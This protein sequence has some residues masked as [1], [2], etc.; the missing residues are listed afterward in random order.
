[1]YVTHSDSPDTP[2]ESRIKNLLYT[3]IPSYTTSDH[4]WHHSPLL[5]DCRLTSVPQKPVV[6]LL[7]LPP[8]ATTTTSVPA[9]HLPEGY[10]PTPDPWANMKKHIGRIL[11]RVVGYTWWLLTLLG[12]GHLVFGVG[13]VLLSVGLWRW[14]KNGAQEGYTQLPS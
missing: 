12:A 4:V 2:Q 14:W 3:A 7:L 11:D 1:M 5:S 6:S 9:I 13:N 8:P 10:R